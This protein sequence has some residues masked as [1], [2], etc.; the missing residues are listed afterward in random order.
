M[1][2]PLFAKWLTRLPPLAR[3]T[4]S[5]ARRGFHTPQQP[6]QLGTKR[7]RFGPRFHGKDDRS[8]P[9][10]RSARALFGKFPSAVRELAAGEHISAVLSCRSGLQDAIFDPLAGHALARRF[11]QQRDGSGMS[12]VGIAPFGNGAGWPAVNLGVARAQD[13]GAVLRGHRR[14]FIPRFGKPLG[15]GGSRGKPSTGEPDENQP[16][17]HVDVLPF[18]G[19]GQGRGQC[20]EPMRTALT[21][22]KTGEPTAHAPSLICAP[23]QEAIETKA[24]GPLQYCPPLR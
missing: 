9:P 10:R 15:V 3:T 5:A 6:R 7:R 21:S 11:A 14:G 20:G 2:S 18:T 1:N 23:P 13:D 16:G 4:R 8:R 19:S 17:P 12:A 22:I 24:A